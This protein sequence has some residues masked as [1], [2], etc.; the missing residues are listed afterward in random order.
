MKSPKIYGIPVISNAVTFL[1]LELFGDNY[2]GLR[3]SSIIFSLISIFLFH[4]I[5][6]KLTTDKFLIF[7]L[8]L[9]FAL[10]FNFSLASMIVEPTIARM[11][12]MMVMMF[13]TILICRSGLL[14]KHILIWGGGS[15]ILVILTYPTNAFVFVGIGL[16]LM[17]T[18]FAKSDNPSMLKRL[19]SATA[20][21]LTLAIGI[22][23]GVGLYLLL[24]KSVGLDEVSAFTDRTA[25]F[26]YRIGN[27]SSAILNNL[28]NICWS[29]LF[30]FNAAL[31]VFFLTALIFIWA[32]SI[33][34]WTIE[35]ICAWS[36]TIALLA[37][38]FFVNDYPQRKLVIFLPLALLMIAGAVANMKSRMRI[39]S[40]ASGLALRA[41][42]LITFIG[43]TYL[44][45]RVFYQD[46][47]HIL[48]T[49]S[50]ICSYIVCII[51]IGLL[52]FEPKYVLVASCIVAFVPEFI[53]ITNHFVTHR[54]IYYK[55][56]LIRLRKYE[57]SEF[58][59]GFSM[60]FR[61]Y[62][63]IKMRLNFYAYYSDPELF[64]IKTKELSKA[65]PEKTFSIGYKSQEEDY[66]KIGFYPVE[67]LIK[68]DE[69]VD[70][71]DIMVFEE[72]N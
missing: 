68:A 12:M 9:F 8:T 49:V 32:A 16:C 10:N 29:N 72:K 3:L 63:K 39:S 33:I 31:L 20:V 50:F 6:K 27:T 36:F 55:E 2:L 14:Y 18:A 38:T 45:T 53:N 66:K 62:N 70:H 13:I 34:N 43:G 28:I 7:V 57:G 26:S 37:Q 42:L 64:W 21:G 54:T 4:V 60:G 30:V 59:G 1:C 19:A 56:A 47:R 51:F 71:G 52:F 40:K 41:A 25:I 61:P 58:I 22:G 69:A 65:N 35:L 48:L 15:V 17:L 5:L 44:I 46:Y 23:L 24:T 11:A 67:V